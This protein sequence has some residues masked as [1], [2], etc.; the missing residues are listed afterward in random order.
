MNKVLAFMAGLLFS[1]F[2]TASFSL[3]LVSEEEEKKKK[4]EGK[5]KAKA[6][7]ALVF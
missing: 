6:I 4:I 5:R 2:C 7:V 3:C 1:I